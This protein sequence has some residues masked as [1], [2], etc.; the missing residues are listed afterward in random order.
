M[1]AFVLAAGRGERMRPLTDTLP[2]P[3]VPLKGKAL[4]DYQLEKLS[5]AGIQDVIVNVAYLGEQVVEHLQKQDHVKLNIMISREPEP[6]E[7]G[8]ALY[9]ARELIG[10][11]DILLVNGDVW[12][13]INYSNVIEN[14]LALGCVAK[15]GAHLVLVENP[16]FK[17][18]GDFSLDGSALKFL[19]ESE[20]G[21]TFSGVSVLS[22]KLLNCY[23][24]MREK[25]PLKEI[26][27][28]GILNQK[29][30]AEVFT[31]YWNDV[32]TPER[33]K[34]VENFIS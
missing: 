23:P 22:S 28:W 10:N 21:F 7:T 32:G 1:K 17:S 18:V 12:S 3:L 25:F 16:A 33:L 31:A 30:S 5:A 2:K 4:I 20:K 11:D 13:E 14:A 26:F 29:I 27:D 34:E 19:E 24:E 6:L 15:G 8:G 9:H